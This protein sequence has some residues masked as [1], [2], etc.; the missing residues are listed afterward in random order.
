MVLAEVLSDNLNL[1]AGPGTFF[2]SLG[3]YLK[4]ST[5]LTLEM[6]ADGDWIKV[7]A[8]GAGGP[9]VGWMAS[10]FLDLTALDAALPVREWPAEQ[11][12]T[13]TVTDQD[14]KAVSAARIALTTDLEG[15][16]QRAEAV[17]NLAGEFAF[18]LPPDTVGPFN[19]EIVALNCGSN[20]ATLQPDGSCTAT[21]HF[22]THW[23]ETISLPQDRPLAF[24]YEKGITALEG[25]VAYQDGNG[26]SQILVRATRTS[27]SVQSEMVTP[28]GGLFRLPLGLG[29]WEVVAVRF[30]QD[31]TPLLSETRIFKVTAAEEMLPYLTIPY[32]EIAER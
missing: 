4:G 9:R 31:G 19:L 27:D 32:N 15:T 14:G 2:E 26:A 8:P 25:I 17:S 20:I 5:V 13:G 3:G 22:P 1:R 10:A 28:V 24:T 29:T 6:T 7:S 30:L 23:R 12:L 18:Y 21:N 11:T 16:E